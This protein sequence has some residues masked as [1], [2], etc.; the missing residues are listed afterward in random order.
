MS[1]CVSMLREKEVLNKKKEKKE[2]DQMRVML[3]KK[4][5]KILK[6]REKKLNIVKM[7]LT[8]RLE[9]IDKNMKEYSKHRAEDTS[10]CLISL[11]IF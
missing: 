2:K 7:I 6:A 5:Y 8:T 4:S 11:C 10:Q 9:S 1:D 3:I